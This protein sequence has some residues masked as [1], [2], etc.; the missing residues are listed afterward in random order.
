MTEAIKPLEGT[1]F[2]A[3]EVEPPP[4]ELA[5][6]YRGEL[7]EA[8]AAARREFRD[9]ARYLGATILDRVREPIDESVRRVGG[10]T[11]RKGLERQVAIEAGVLK[12]Y[13]YPMV[14]STPFGECDFASLERRLVD[15]D[16]FVSSYRAAS[17]GIGKYLISDLEQLYRFRSFVD[18]HTKFD[19]GDLMHVREY[20]DTT[21]SWRVNSNASG[22]VQA[23]G[24]LY[25]D[26]SVGRPGLI[27][28]QP[29]Q[30][31]NADPS[32]LLMVSKPE[33]PYSRHFLKSPEFRSNYNINSRAIPVMGANLDLNYSE[34]ERMILEQHGIDSRNP[35]LPLDLIEYTRW[36][37]PRL[38]PWID[39]TV[40]IDFLQQ[41]G[42][43]VKFYLEVNGG[44][45]PHMNNICNFAGK[46]TSQEAMIDMQL[47]GL[48]AIAW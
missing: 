32:I 21:T 11:N 18:T 5:G 36:L 43:N 26:E 20:I 41:K 2:Y 31:T 14:S 28:T 27:V 44:A 3:P 22:E 24:L 17:R 15:G 40:G 16:P 23:A 33:N 35:T 6:T 7:W 29:E 47:V 42:T 25:R 9:H 12:D 4:A 45:G 39:I 10:R 46:A 34:K 19:Y 8:S 13:P 37:G 30:L 38:T 1:V 48:Y